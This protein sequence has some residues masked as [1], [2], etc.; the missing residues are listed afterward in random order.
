MKDKIK[1][2]EKNNVIL[3]RL[4]ITIIMIGVVFFVAIY[5]TNEDVRSYINRNILKNELTENSIKAIEISSE[6]N[7]DIYAY[8]KYITVFGKNE[9]KLY[10][11]SSNNVKTLN[12]EISKPIMASEENYLLIAESEG[13]TLYLIKDT[14]IVWK[15]EIDGSISKINV[16]ENGYV[17]IIVKNN[18]Y[19]SIIYVYNPDGTQLF[20]RYISSTLAISTDIS[21]DNK[22]LVFGEVDYSGIT[23]KSNV[24]IISMELAIKEP[25]NSTEKKYSAE[26]GKILIDVR[27]TDNNKIIA[28][29]NDSIIRYSGDEEKEIFKIEKENIFVDIGLQNNIVSFAKESSGMFS[30]EYKVIIKNEES[31]KENIY[32]LNSSIPKKVITNKNAIGMNFGT[33]VK[34]INSNAW[35]LKEYKSSKQIKDLVLGT[36]IAGIVYKDKIEIISF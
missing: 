27:Y 14:D 11:S 7:L 15:D 8:S 32:V 1:H 5:T 28:M 26:Q 10:D 34:I 12:V 2:K 9:L 4:A 35:L 24:E 3:K 19:K 21:K 23:V 22:Y 18:T 20:K 29:Y 33:E 31:E 6:N 17:S 25:L 16:N 36:S 30:F 13:K